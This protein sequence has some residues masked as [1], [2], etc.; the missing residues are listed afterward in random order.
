MALDPDAVDRAAAAIEAA[1]GGLTPP[2]DAALLHPLCRD[3]ND[4]AEFYGAPDWHALPGELL[5]RNYAAPAFFSAAGFRYYLPAFMV[6]ALR[7]AAS[8]EY[9]AEA[10]LRAFDPGR[11]SDPLYGFQ[12]SKFALFDTAQRRAVVT[13]LESFREDDDLGPLAEAALQNYWSS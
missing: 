8:P 10:T 4:I 5:V 6:W 13:F 12:V 3:D 9:L 11:E 1:F 2:G 7:N